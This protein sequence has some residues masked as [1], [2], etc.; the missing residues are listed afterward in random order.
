MKDL[1]VSETKRSI[2]S[3]GEVVYDAVPIK[4][5]TQDGNKLSGDNKAKLYGDIVSNGTELASKVLDIVKLREQ[6]DASLKT[7]DKQIELV[8]R[9]T[10]SEIEKMIAQTD[11]WEKRFNMVSKVLQ[12]MTIT[13]TT[14]KDLNPEVAKS[15]VD[16]VRV[17]VEN[18]SKG[19]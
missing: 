19:V 3:K 11:N 16:T 10:K 9:T 7:M 14:N 12:D 18:I 1:R 17:M 4:A 13:V 15:L 2:N 8:E 6:T 5:E